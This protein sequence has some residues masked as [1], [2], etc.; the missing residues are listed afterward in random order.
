[1][2]H[3]NGAD[4]NTAAE[5][6]R[7]PVEYVCQMSRTTTQDD[8]NGSNQCL[9]LTEISPLYLRVTNRNMFRCLLEAGAVCDTRCLEYFHGDTHVHEAVLEKQT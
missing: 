1:M 5:M 2:L 3:Q 4:V 8:S 6:R 9:T 7:I